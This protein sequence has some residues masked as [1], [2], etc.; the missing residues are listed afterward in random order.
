M[1]NRRARP[2]MLSRDELET[3]VIVA[4]RNAKLSPKV[5]AAGLTVKPTSKSA[6]RETIVL[7]SPKA[8]VTRIPTKSANLEWLMRDVLST[9]YSTILS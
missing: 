3:A 9:P 6:V 2:K 5:R 4:K 8:T 7:S 1:R